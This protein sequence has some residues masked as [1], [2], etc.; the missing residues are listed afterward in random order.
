VLLTLLT[1]LLLLLLLLPLLPPQAVLV[2]LLT[3]S[4]EVM[5]LRCSPPCFFSSSCCCPCCCHRLC[6]CSC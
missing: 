5:S 1:L 6:W 4:R 3:M 2:Q